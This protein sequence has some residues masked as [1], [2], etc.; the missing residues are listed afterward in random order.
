VSQFRAVDLLT[1]L[2]EAIIGSRPL[3][4]VFQPRNI[5]GTAVFDIKLTDRVPAKS[6]TLR[7][8]VPELKRFTIT[9]ISAEGFTF[10]K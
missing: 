6:I 1:I 10:L 8:T 9:S 5:N 2:S 4:T 3:E 7:F